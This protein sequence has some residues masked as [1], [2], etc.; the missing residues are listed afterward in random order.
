VHPKPFFNFIFFYWLAMG[1]F[2][3]PKEVLKI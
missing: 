1:H 2:D 3:I